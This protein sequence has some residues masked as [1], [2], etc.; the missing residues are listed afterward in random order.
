MIVWWTIAIGSASIITFMGF[1]QGFDRWAEY[2]VFT[3]MAVFIII[4]R[5]FMMKRVNKNLTEGFE[6]KK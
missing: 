5:L 2:Y 4:V 6:N 1:K 3:A